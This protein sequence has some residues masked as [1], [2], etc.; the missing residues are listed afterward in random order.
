M[1]RANNM[2]DKLEFYCKEL[3]KHNLL[4][5]FFEMMLTH[6]ERLNISN[7]LLIIQELL[8]GTKT[9]RQ[10]AKEYNVSIS[11]ITIGSNQLKDISKK[12]QSQL[13]ELNE[14]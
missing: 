8:K 2:Y 10:I 5:D 3:S 12:L 7:R 11:Q 4:G 9:Q 14:Q 6:E 1:N 13:L